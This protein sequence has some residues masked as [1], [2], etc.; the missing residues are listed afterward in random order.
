MTFLLFL[1]VL[2][3]GVILNDTR[4][5]LK[6][7]E[8]RLERER[9]EGEASLYDNA[10]PESVHSSVSV[11]RTAQTARVIHGTPASQTGIG[12]DDEG[13]N[14]APA[15]VV[16]GEQPQDAA[17]PVSEVRDEA[18]APGWAA[19]DEMRESAAEEAHVPQL[20]RAAAFSFEDIFGRKLPIWAGGITLAIAAILLVKYSIDAGLL[21][22]AVRVV[23]GLLFGGSLIGGAEWALRE[24]ERVGDERIR[25]ALAGA[26]IASLYASILA[27]VNL[28]GLVSGGVAFAGL[29][30]TTALAM[31]LSLRFGMPSAILGLIGGLAAPALVGSTAPNIPLLCGYLGLAIGGLTAVARHQRWAWLGVGALLG[32]AGWSLLLMMTGALSHADAL[33]IGLLVM[34]LALALP[35]VAFRHGGATLLRGASGLIGAVQMALLVGMGGFEMLHWGLYGLLSAGILWL[36]AREAALR[37]FALLGLAV[38]LMLAAVWPHPDGPE[39]RLVMLAM[40]GLY[41][42]PALLR[43]WR[44]G[45]TMIEAL[46][47][48]AISLGGY[49]VTLYHFHGALDDKTSALLALACAFLPSVAAALG[50]KHEDRRNSA[51]FAI[52]SAAAS[53]LLLMAGHYGLPDMWKAVAAAVV[54]AL[55][56]EISRRMRTPAPFVAMSIFAGGAALA[57]LWPLVQW[58]TAATFSLTGKPLYVT[59]LSAPLTTFWKLAV[60]ALLSGFAVWR[61]WPMLRHGTGIGLVAMPAVCAVASAHIFYKQMFALSDHFEFVQY[62]LAER[63]VWE[64]LIMGAGFALW[65]RLREAQVALL[66][67]ATATAHGLWYNILLHNPM[68]VDQ[69]VGPAPLANLLLGVYGLPMLALWVGAQILSERGQSAPRT[70]DVG[71]MLLVLLGAYAMLRQLFAGSLLPHASVS[72]FEN[73]LRSVVAIVLAIGFLLWGIRTDKSDWRIGSLVLILAA[74]GKVF[75]FDISG[76]TGLLRIMSFLALG[77]SLIGIGWLYSRFLKS[78]PR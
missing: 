62:G 72:E 18:P 38:A 57:A 55:A 3:M 68:T 52:V 16:P 64:A 40:A 11:P 27:A 60:P 20:Q 76:L 67:V 7:V 5:R 6:R 4:S 15:Q 23:L 31:G 2:V 42:A 14:D 44:N 47:I 22:P 50:W 13:V 21:S 9:R 48:G 61:I 74:V 30:A 45:G 39:F 29:A 28:Y 53:L 65:R 35:T 49:L 66:L 33:A 26:G 32:G 77:F 59:D 24:E 34:L 36:S 63:L 12:Q 71:R 58:G 41:G 43:L 75:L 56:G 1:A 17:N 69:A 46:A 70:F 37:P 25:Q 10:L 73:I 78:E 19:A 51:R 54:V 8:V